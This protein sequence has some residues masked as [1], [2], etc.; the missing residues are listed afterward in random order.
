MTSNL[1][2]VT[3]NLRPRGVAALES[4][5]FCVGGKTDAVERSLVA[6]AYL[7]KRVSEGVELRL[8]YPT[9]AVEAVT[10]L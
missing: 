9:G 10:F 6:Y 1:T 5:M 3:V 8:H 2:R 4:L 7:S